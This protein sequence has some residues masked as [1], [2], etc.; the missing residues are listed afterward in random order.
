MHVQLR[1]LL[2]YVMHNMR[3]EW[4]GKSFCL[5]MCVWYWIVKQKKSL[6]RMPEERKIYNIKA[7][8]YGNLHNSNIKSTMDV[9]DYTRYGDYRCDLVLDMKAAAVDSV[10]GYL[11]L[12]LLEPL[13]LLLLLLL[14]C[15]YYRHVRRAIDSDDN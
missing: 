13:W 15:Y 5:R 3:N 11:L 7:E 12:L 9:S 1:L 6:K 2:L 14:S 8:I 10:F 4:C